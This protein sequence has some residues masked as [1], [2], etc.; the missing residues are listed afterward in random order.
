MR[1]VF[2]LVL[3]LGLA[4][5]G[6]AVYLAQNYMGRMQAQSVKERAIL[7]KVGP[8]TEAYVVNKPLAFGSVLTKNDVEKVYWPKKSMPEGMFTE[9]EV[10]FPANSKGDRYVMRQMDK[11]EPLLANKVTEPGQM[12]GLQLSQGMR[13]FTIKVDETRSVSGFLQ[14]GHKVDVYWTGQSGVSAEEITRLIENAVKVVAVDQSSNTDGGAAAQ[15]AKTVTVEAT[16]EQV[17]R[18]AQAQATGRLAL[19]LVGSDDQGGAS[20]SIEVST[21]DFGGAAPVAAPVVEQKIC[22]IKQRNGT[23]IIEV[24]IACTN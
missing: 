11:F 9:E 18:L 19:S 3:V 1:M 22:T 21:A 16:Q 12:A 8:L 2:G 24:P 20:G 4:L 10:L 6:G 15:I 7:E 13:A 14:P 5:A 17:A 23:E